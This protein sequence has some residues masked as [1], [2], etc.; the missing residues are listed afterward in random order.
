M[1]EGESAGVEGA[2][3]ADPLF[4]PLLLIFR[5]APRPGQCS[6]VQRSTVSQENLHRAVLPPSR[7]EQYARII[8]GVKANFDVNLFQFYAGYRRSSV[9][10]TVADLEKRWN[11]YPLA[12]VRSRSPLLPYSQRPVANR[13]AGWE[14]EIAGAAS[15]IPRVMINGSSCVLAPTCQREPSPFATLRADPPASMACGFTFRIW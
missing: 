4:A 14:S 15:A 9:R 1:H 8:L 13:P 12:R 11:H 5:V 7:C 3:D 10:P 2:R 6:A